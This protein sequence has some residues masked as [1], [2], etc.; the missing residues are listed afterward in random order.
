[1]NNTLRIYLN[2]GILDMQKGNL[3]SAEIN[4]K[5]SLKKFPKQYFLNTFLIPCLIQQKK[6]EEALRYAI[7][8]HKNGTMLE[9]SS[10]Y[11]GIIYF[12]TSQLILALKY[13]DAALSINANNY[14]ALVNKAGVLHKLNKNSDAMMSLDKALNIKNNDLIAYR[15]YASIYEDELDFNQ[16]EKYYL[17]ALS[18]HPNNHKT[19]YALSHL[20]LSKKEYQ[21]GWGNFEHRWYKEK[22]RYPNI[23]PLKNLENIKN[24]KI[25][26]WHEQGLGDTIQFSRY[27]RRLLE[28]EAKVVFEV[29]EPLVAFFAKQFSCE[30]TNSPSNMEFDFQSPLLSLPRIFSNEDKYFEF[31]EPYFTSSQEK[32]LFWN[33]ELG[34]CSNKLNLGITISGN[35]KQIHEDRRKISL[36]YF[37]KFLQF[38]KIFLIQKDIS[39]EDKNILNHNKEIIFLGNNT[40]WQNFTDTSAILDNMDY[41]ISIDTSIIH[42]AGSMNKESL[43]L[44]SKP[45]EWRWAQE[46][47][48]TPNWYHSVKI[49]RQKSRRN[50]DT[51]RDDLE[52]IIR[53]VSYKK[54]N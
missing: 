18:F 42:L 12:Q 49:L 1:M 28:L 43:L 21:Q 31:V 16:S 51:I 52:K 41:L 9:H 24:K 14:D 33:K 27:V 23:A 7:P 15:N 46:D 34:L 5:N 38:C 37:T 11:L 25:L 2:N 48:Q 35:T 40:S 45:A 44:L 10:I 32:K 50:W 54:F 53:D 36:S 8:F 4:F 3:L 22:F 20:Q 17:K 47:D 6:Y 30:I 26:I 19:L 39:K 29:Q 13:F